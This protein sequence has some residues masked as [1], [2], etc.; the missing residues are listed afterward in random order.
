VPGRG[1]DLGLG[2]TLKQRPVILGGNERG[3]AADHGQV[4]GVGKLPAAEVR[5]AQVPDLALGNQLMQC[6]DG[7]LD[8][9]HRIRR[10]QL[11]QIDVVGAQPP[12]RLGHG[13]PDVG[14]AALG[15][16][17]RPVAH[18]SALVAELGGQDD[19]IP[20]P[21]E[22]LAERALGPAASAVGVGRVEQGD[23]GVDGRVHHRACPVEVQASAE[24]VTAEPG[25][26]YH[27]S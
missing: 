8:R 1:H 16:R 6:R 7:L 2:R 9:G 24:V 23:A 10:V 26:R 11:V 13:P 20:A 12:Q 27:E 21:A 22:D 15:P 5:V 18:V 4:R 19:L 14:P 17:G 3:V 25:H